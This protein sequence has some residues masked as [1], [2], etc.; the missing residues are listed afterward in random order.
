[1]LRSR[2][3]IPPA[4][5]TAKITFRSF[6]NKHNRHKPHRS[7]RNIPRSGLLLKMDPQRSSKQTKNDP[8]TPL[9]KI[10]QPNQTNLQLSHQPRNQTQ[11]WRKRRT[12]S[13]KLSAKQ[14]PHNIHS[15]QRTLTLKQ[16]QMENI[17]HHIPR[18]HKLKNKKAKS[19]NNLIKQKPKVFFFL[20]LCRH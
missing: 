8:Q 13:G 18:P 19:N 6:L 2:P 17:H 14:N 10:L 5:S 11:P 1:M 16:H 15:R 12:H 3:R 9:H 4:H 20:I 7:S